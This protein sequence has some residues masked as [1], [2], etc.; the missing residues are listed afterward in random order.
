MRKSCNLV[1]CP[2]SILGRHGTMKGR[3]LVPCVRIYDLRETATAPQGLWSP[4]SLIEHGTPA[5][6]TVRS[7]RRMLLSRD[8]PTTYIGIVKN[9]QLRETERWPQQLLASDIISETSYRALGSTMKRQRSCLRLTV[10]CWGPC[11]TLNDIGPSASPH[12]P[13]L[14]SVVLLPSSTETP[15]SHPPPPLG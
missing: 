4:S 1:L 8:S 15:T 14:C 10:P 11:L 2:K 7:L 5:S 3:C 12:H 6:T 13:A 9:H